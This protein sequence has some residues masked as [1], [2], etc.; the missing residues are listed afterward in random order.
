MSRLIFD[1]VALAR[2]FLLGMLSV[3]LITAIVGITP[4]DVQLLPCLFQS[5]CGLQCPGCGM[6]RACA[7]IGQGRFV[8][9]Y[10]WHPL[11][12]GLVALA[13]GMALWPTRIRQGWRRLARWQQA[14]ILTACFLAVL[15]VWVGRLA[16]GWPG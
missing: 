14:M 3:G 4:G 15:G 2:L 1:D 9:A 5:I 11:A 7:A 13:A 8:E 16:N 6:T 10:H 12:F